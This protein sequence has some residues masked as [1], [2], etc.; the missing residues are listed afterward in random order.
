MNSTLLGITFDDWLN[1]LLILVG[2]SAFII[3]WLQE[4]KKINEA[5]S[6]I[7]LQIEEFQGRV[8][9]LS[10]FVANQ[11]LNDTNFYESLPLMDTNYWDKYKHYFVLKMDASSY[12]VINSFYQYLAEIQEQHSLMKNLQKNNF[13]VNQNVIAGIESQFIITYFNNFFMNINNSN[14]ITTLENKLPLNITEE[15]KKCLKKILQEIPLQPTNFDINHFW[16]IYQQE[17]MQFETIINQKAL[18][19][20]I[21]EQIRMSLEKILKK[22]SMLE[23][24][25][26]NGYRKL[27]KY[28]TRWF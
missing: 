12:N 18:T 24:T 1:I 11:Q 23:I 25:G 21:P 15:E 6:L 10:T 8:R 13:F 19:Y 22:Y 27:K 14:L 4:R 28:S 17:K 5:A 3:Y 2:L 16:S 26:T 9:E 7:V 20:Y